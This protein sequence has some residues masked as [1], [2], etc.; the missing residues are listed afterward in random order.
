MNF[1]KRLLNLGSIILCAMF[2]VIHGYNIFTMQID[3]FFAGVAAGFVVL[4]IGCGLNYL[5]HG[6]ATIWNKNTK[7]SEK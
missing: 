3:K 1:M 5:V 7:S 4:G 6:E 2:V